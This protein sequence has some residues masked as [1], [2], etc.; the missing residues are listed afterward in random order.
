MHPKI[1]IGSSSEGQQATVALQRLLHQDLAGK[2]EL[3]PWTHVFELSSTNIESLEK[4][5]SDADFAILVFTADDE[6]TLRSGQIK[7]PRDN[8]TFEL[9]LFTGR[10]GRERCYLVEE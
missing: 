6:L 1:F 2:V 10:L 4:A 9:G 5:A 3:L 7:A 8:V